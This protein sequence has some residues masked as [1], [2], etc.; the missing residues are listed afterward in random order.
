MGFRQILQPLL[1]MLTIA[2][3]WAA[4][5]DH[6]VYRKER[7]QAEKREREAEAQSSKARQKLADAELSVDSAV[8]DFGKASEKYR[9]AFESSPE[10]TSAQSAMKEAQANRDAAVTPVLD[11]LK[12]Q[13]SYKAALEQK[14]KASADLDRLRSAGTG[15]AQLTE[16]AKKVTDAAQELSRQELE[17]IKADSNTSTTVTKLAEAQKHCAELKGKFNDS[18]KHTPELAGPR[19]ALASA[20]ETRDKASVE[21]SEALQKEKE[22]HDDVQVAIDRER[23]H[24]KKDLK[25]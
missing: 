13:P 9:L 12:A 6:Q 15:T 25:L 8:K 7:E 11:T 19:D 3:A 18:L 17:A 20:R 1:V 23:G 14:S 24:K 5:T 10:W 22:A 16:A 2:P 21:L 4:P